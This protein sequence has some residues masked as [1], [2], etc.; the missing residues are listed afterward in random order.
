VNFELDI[1]IDLATRAHAGTSHVPE[2]RAAQER[3]DYANTLAADLAELGALANTPEKRELLESEFARYRAG[4]RRRFTDRLATAAQC[5]SPLVTGP[6][7]FPAERARKA[8][9]RADKASAEL[10]EFRTRALAAIRKRLCPE[11]RPIMA[12]DADALERL[13][14]K[15]AGLESTHALMVEANKMIRVSARFGTD[16]QVRELVDLGFV[17]TDART[18]L[19]PDF[20]NRIGFPGYAL[21][22]SNAEIGRIRA[23]IAALTTAKATPDETVEGTAARLVVATAEN[24]VRLFFPSKPA[25]DVIAALKAHAFR[26]TP[27]LG[28]WQAYVNHGSVTFARQTAGFPRA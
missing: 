10:V 14:I 18:L 9:T 25:A 19:V 12:G 24:R 23:R 26:W 27:S 8:S 13:A 21:T 28:C 22:N 17:E 7:N 20:C 11:L 15:L 16:A 3:A 1:P 5:V 2:R 4:Y 6:A